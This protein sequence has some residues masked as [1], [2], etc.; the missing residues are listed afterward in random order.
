MNVTTDN[1]LE[2]LVNLVM[3]SSIVVF[4]VY[5]IKLFLNGDN[6]D[7]TGIWV[8]VLGLMLFSIA[9]LIEN[10]RLRLKLQSMNG[11]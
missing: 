5:D 7:I 3:W 11:I 9:L 10:V 2:W 6:F 8:P 4:G 1:K